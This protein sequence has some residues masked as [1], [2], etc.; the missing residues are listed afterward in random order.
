MDY[1][2]DM[3]GAL[4]IAVKGLNEIV[5]R[6]SPK[7]FKEWAIIREELTKL[8]STESIFLE[9]TNKQATKIGKLFHT[10]MENMEKAATDTAAETLVNIR[11]L[12]EAEWALA[13]D[14]QSAQYNE[15][16]YKNIMG[17]LPIPVREETE[18]EVYK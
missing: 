1:R 8:L 4:A 10:W 12:V 18:K 14:Q 6:E 16:I 2:M 5:L 9:D 7:D 3:G 11:M 15:E 13:K 17:Q